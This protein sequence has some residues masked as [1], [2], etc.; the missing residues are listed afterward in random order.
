MNAAPGSGA[1]GDCHVKRDSPLPQDKG[2]ERGAVA[3]IQ[4]TARLHCQL[5]LT[6]RGRRSAG[7]YLVKLH[8]AGRV[9]ELQFIF[10]RPSREYA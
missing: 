3:L 6:G 2:V 8:S 7:G 5:E 9:N 4:G 1:R 10:C